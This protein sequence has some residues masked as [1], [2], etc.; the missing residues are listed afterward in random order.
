MNNREIFYHNIAQ[1]SPAPLAFEVTKASGIYL[2]DSHDNAYIDLISGI[3]VSNV[4]HCNPEVTSAIQ[5]QAE[6]YAHVMVYGEYVQSAQTKLAEHLLS[7]LPHSLNNIYYTNSG[8]EATE[9]AMKLAKRY[10]KRHKFVS[11]TH[12]YHGSTQGALSMMGDEYFKQN[13]RPLLPNCFQ[14]LYNNADSLTE[15]DEE[16][17]AVFFEPVQAES[18]VITPSK[19]FVDKLVSRCKQV[20]ALLVADEIQ[21]GFGRTGSLFAFEKMGFT[22]DILLIGKAFGAGLPLGAFIAN[23][24]IMQSFMQNPVL[25]H[26]TTFGGNPICC[27]AATASLAYLQK[28]K[29]IDT[30]AEK[31]TYFKELLIHP[32]IKQIRSCGLLMSIEFENFEQNQKVIHRCLLN[33]LLTDWFLFAPNFM[34]IAPP[35]II[36]FDEI[37]KACHI[38]LK[39]I[40]QAI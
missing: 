40:D 12:S 28:N 23:R 27:S 7:V 14:I 19:A 38:I 31:E 21:T 8:A 5:H 15:I 29:L 1:T 36:T 18:G 10:T 26:I 11:F 13:Y 16:T 3:S 6:T 39:S 32:S 4:G 20:G 37:K 33:G 34:R 30:V 9:G 2:F 24:S 17:A 25:G 22:P 35:L